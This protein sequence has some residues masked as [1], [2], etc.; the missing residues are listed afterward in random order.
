MAVCDLVVSVTRAPL[1]A[2]TGPGRVIFGDPN[3][4]G[5]TARNGMI[6]HA[7]GC[8]AVFHSRHVGRRAACR[9]AAEPDHRV[10]PDRHARHIGQRPSSLIAM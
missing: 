6:G 5:E 2:Y 4:K 8:E 1:R 3:E 10:C 7:A 9:C